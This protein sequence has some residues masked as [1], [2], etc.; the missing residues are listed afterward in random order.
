M[1]LITINI[2]R[3]IWLFNLYD[4]NPR[5]RAFGPDLYEWLKATYGFTNLQR[6]PE[7][8][9][10]IESIKFLDGKFKCGYEEDGTEKCIHVELSMYNDG[11]LADTRSSTKDADQFLNDVLTSAAKQFSLAYQ[12][13]M[14]RKKL[15]YSELDIK[16]GKEFNFLNPQLQGF[17]G[18]ISS[19]LDGVPF[20]FS[21]LA[22]SV[23]PNPPWQYSPFKIERRINTPWPENRY[24]SCAPLHTE[25]HI[26]LLK[27]FEQNLLIHH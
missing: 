26:A 20:E 10:K 22:F 6:S 4:L 15:Y 21:G 16:L 8:G 17:A 14:I 24:F 27:E 19:L 2:A 25:D 5:G 11:V 13:N 7:S 23:H 3:S 9:G 12:P 18:K 1:Q